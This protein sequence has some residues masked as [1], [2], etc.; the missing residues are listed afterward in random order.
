MNEIQNKRIDLVNLIINSISNKNYKKNGVEK[1]YIPEGLNNLYTYY[2]Y[3]NIDAIMGRCEF[4]D[5]EID[6]ITTKDSIVINSIFDAQLTI[7]CL[8][9]ES[10]IIIK[11]FMGDKEVFSI[12]NYKNVIT[13]RLTTY[14][15][16]QM[17]RK[18]YK[19]DLFKNEFTYYAGDIK[20]PNVSD[21]DLDYIAMLI[22][23][24]A[25]FKDN[26]VFEFRRI[27]PEEKQAA[28]LFKRIVDSVKGGGYVSI[29]TSSDLVDTT[30][31][32]DRIFGH[33]KDTR[34]NE[35]EKS[36]KRENK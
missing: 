36:L 1:S 16:N 21:D 12:Q 27:K 9:T 13:N 18:V 31:F 32:A 24:N 10:G 26:E 11:G 8:Q 33:M 35:K 15:N 23:M 29:Q 28:S 20:D 2:M 30:Y 19:S 4:D 17:E 6:I 3:E 5:D 7:N 22:P 34:K 25:K 14:S